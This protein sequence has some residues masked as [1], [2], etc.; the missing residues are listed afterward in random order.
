[1]RIPRIHLPIP[2]VVATTAVLSG[3]VFNHAVR[4]L[5][6]KEG[7]SLILFNGE[8]GE[9]R[10]IVETVR[11]HE[12]SVRIEAFIAREA[13]SSLKVLL[14]QGISRGERMDYTLQKAVELGVSTI[15]PLV[16]ERSV[17]NSAERRLEKRLFHWR[18]V[19]A[20]ACEQCGRNRLPPVLQP[21]PLKKWL[22]ACRNP[23]LGLVL[24]PSA[25]KGLR[26]LSRPE[27]AIT[28]LV[29]PEGG[30][31]RGETELAQTAH[32]TPIRLGPRVLRTE[33]AGAVALAALQLLW[34]DLL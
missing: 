9:F 17:L 4:V 30:L 15:L 7:A 16:T 20:S 2:L 8:G 26:T 13:E 25:A 10:A 23:G 6:L 5:R 14:A 1:M 21:Q 3:A 22:A 11:R 29:G 27:S 12:A 24:Q 19:V 32:F 34:G 18:G 28:L 33:T 31:S